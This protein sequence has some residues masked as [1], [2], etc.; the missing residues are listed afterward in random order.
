MN[1]VYKSLYTEVDKEWNRLWKSPPA[2]VDR[3]APK[4]KIRGLIQPPNPGNTLDG[5]V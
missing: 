3:G 4:Q 5:T 2:A 1:K